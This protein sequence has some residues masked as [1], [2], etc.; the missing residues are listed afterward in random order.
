M[1]VA[2]WDP[3]YKRAAKV[4]GELEHTTVLLDRAMKRWALRGQSPLRYELDSM[5]ILD[6]VADSN[7]YI[8]DKLSQGGEITTSTQNRLID[9]AKE[10]AKDLE[11]VVDKIGKAIDKRLQPEEGS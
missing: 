7:G 3:A 9:K 4:R 8:Q 6:E 2:S 10:N 1:Q 11:R 5:E